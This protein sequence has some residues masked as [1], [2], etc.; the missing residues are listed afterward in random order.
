MWAGPTQPHIDGQSQPCLWTHPLA[1]GVMA[2]SWPWPSGEATALT[3]F[4]ALADS[5]FQGGAWQG[6]DLR[7]RVW[8][9]ERLLVEHLQPTRPGVI[10]LDVALDA[11]AGGSPERLRVTVEGPEDG[12][13][14][15]CWELRLL[16]P[17][18]SRPGPD[19]VIQRPR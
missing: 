16:G 17:E 15:F 5:A 4:S 10:P 6:A 2:W 3:G 7:L 8:A 12:R 13:R 1:G 14:H 9:D 11:T 19:G 18:G